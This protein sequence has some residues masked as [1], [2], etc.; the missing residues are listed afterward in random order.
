MQHESA[1]GAKAY[2]SPL[3]AEFMLTAASICWEIV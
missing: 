2:V 3:K 1:Y